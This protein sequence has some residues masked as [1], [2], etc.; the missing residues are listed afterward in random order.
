MTEQQLIDKG[1]ADG[2]KSFEYLWNE[3]EEN[4]KWEKVYTVMKALDWVWHF[5]NNEYGI[6]DI[7]TIKKHCRKNLFEIYENGN[8][9]YSTGGFTGR[10]DGENLSLLFTVEGWETN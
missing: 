9:S 4:F 5:H 7:R 10:Y 2:K 1:Y 6:P 3:I 8:G